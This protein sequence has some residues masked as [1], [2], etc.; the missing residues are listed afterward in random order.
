M[1]KAD[2]VFHSSAGTDRNPSNLPT[3]FQLIGGGVK[4]IVKGVGRGLLKTFVDPSIKVSKLKDERM[5]KMR[6]DFES[7]DYLNQ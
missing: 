7:G 5:N 6:R 2:K 4:K 3:P 1:N